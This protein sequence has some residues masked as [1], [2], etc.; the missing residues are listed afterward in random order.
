MILGL[1]EVASEPSHLDLAGLR[2]HPLK[3]GRRGE[4]SLRVNRN[5]RITFRFEGEDVTDVDYEDYH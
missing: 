4:W 2:L 1:L 3:G 5:W